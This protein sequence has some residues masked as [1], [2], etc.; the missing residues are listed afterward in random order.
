SN[1]LNS[2]GILFVTADRLG[3]PQ[4]IITQQLTLMS[5]AFLRAR[6]DRMAKESLLTQA[7]VQDAFTL[8]AVLQ[9]P[10]IA[11]L[12]TDGAALEGEY[13]RLSQTFKPDYPRMLALKEKIEENRRQLRNETDRTLAS[14]K[15]DYEASVRSEKSLEAS[16]AKQSTLARGL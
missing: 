12:K 10:L 3:Q 11:Q 6:S 2:H 1:Y 15:A 5:E 4:D 9:S 13:R 8:P 14:L 16:L 7:S